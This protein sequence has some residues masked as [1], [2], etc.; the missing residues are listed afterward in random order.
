ME[1]HIQFVKAIVDRCFSGRVPPREYDVEIIAL[2]LE[3][4][5]GDAPPFVQSCFGW[6][7]AEALDCLRRSQNAK[8]VS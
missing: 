8:W 4:F 2:L 5:A 3:R 7:L 6:H 1:V